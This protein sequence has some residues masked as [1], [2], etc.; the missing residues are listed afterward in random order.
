MAVLFCKEERHRSRSL[1]LKIA[2]VIVRKCQGPVRAAAVI[3]G[4]EV[5]PAVRE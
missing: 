5:G 1:F 3:K 4:K 2:L